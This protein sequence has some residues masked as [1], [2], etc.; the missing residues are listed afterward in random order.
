MSTSRS[1]ILELVEQ[2]AEEELFKNEFRPGVDRV[3]VSGKTLFPEDFVSVVDSVLD[4]WFT[5]GRFTKEFEKQLSALVGVRSATFVNSGSSANL[6]AL[7]ALTSPKLGARQLSAGDEVITVAM[8]FPTTINPIIQNQL[9]PVFV[10]VN[11][12]TMDIDVSRLEEAVTSKTKAVMVAHTLGNP[13]E[14]ESIER[15]CKENNLWLI[16]DACDALGSTYDGRA[17]GS[18]GDVASFSF[19]PAH[20]ITTGEGGA[21]MS[22]SPLVTRQIESFRDWGRDCYCETGK[23]D[24]CA[25]RF[26]WKLGDLPEGYDHKYTYSHI[27]Y[28]LKAT[29]MQAALG[30]SQIKKLPDFVDARKNNFRHLHQGLKHFEEFSFI[31]PTPKSDPAWFGFGIT[32][33]DKAKFNRKEFINFLDLAKIDTRLLFAGNALKQPAYMNIE[34]RVHGDLLNTDRIMERSLWL[35]VYPGLS[36]QMLDY[37]IETIDSFVKKSR[38]Q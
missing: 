15:V 12:D 38:R 18:F 14:V 3:P 8:G 10:D 37:V 23:D 31:Q 33:T 36:A 32:L 7:S 34:K 20:H 11:P 19:Y 17:T 29:D 5:G 25:K 21:V 4:G 1:K 2:F 6:C 16:E 30:L 26:G 35:G 9:L 13:F 27:G 28:N 24:T 22:K